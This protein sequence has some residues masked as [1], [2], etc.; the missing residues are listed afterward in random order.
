MRNVG[1]EGNFY[2]EMHVANLERDGSHLLPTL[3]FNQTAHTS[4]GG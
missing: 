2:F 1:L 4:R 3:V